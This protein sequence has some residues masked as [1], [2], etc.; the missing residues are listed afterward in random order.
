M[1][2]ITEGAHVK[3]HFRLALVEEDFLVDDTHADDGEPFDFVVGE[4]EI[5]SGLEA[6]LMGMQPGDSAR[7]EVPAIEGYGEAGVDVDSIQNI[8]MSDFPEGMEL[9]P[10]AV[11]GFT[12]DNGDEIPGTIMGFTDEIVSVDFSHPLVGHDL[13]FEVEIIDVEPPVL[14]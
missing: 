8:P 4:G 1:V 6:R 12:A 10:G 14:Q 11:I 7:F 5:V 9:T 13:I 3:M 2:E